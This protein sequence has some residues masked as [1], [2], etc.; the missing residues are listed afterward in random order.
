MTAFYYFILDCFIFDGLIMH[1]SKALDFGVKIVIWGLKMSCTT[2]TLLLYCF[3]KKY[4]QKKFF[5]GGGRL[6]SMSLFHITFRNEDTDLKH[7]VP[8][9]KTQ[10]K[11][12]PATHV[13]STWLQHT[14]YKIT[15]AA[16]PVNRSLYVMSELMCIEEINM[17]IALKDQAVHEK[18]FNSPDISKSDGCCLHIN[19]PSSIEQCLVLIGRA[20]WGECNHLQ[21]A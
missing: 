16:T 7:Y 5:L 10:Y 4:R 2:L 13:Q 9:Q 6:S 18:C 15:R 21:V 20:V 19:L 8:F 3:K 12:N 14:I 1:E 17:A 11:M